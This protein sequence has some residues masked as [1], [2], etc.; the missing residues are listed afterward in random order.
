MKKILVCGANPA[1]QKVLVF[2]ELKNG[3]V[4]RAQ[5]VL[6]FASGKGIN[7][8]RAVKNYKKAGAELVQFTAG[9]NGDRL[10]NGLDTENII[11]HDIQLADGETRICSTCIDCKNKLMTELIE[12]S[13]ELTAADIEKFKNKVFAETGN[14]DAFAIC[15]TMPAN[16]PNDIYLDLTLKALAEN[17]YV[18]A[19]MIFNL[20]PVLEAS[21]GKVLLKINAD[22]LA[23]FT[24]INSVTD[25]LRMIDKKYDTACA[26]ITDGPGKAYLLFKHRIFE[27]ELVELDNVVNAIGCGDTASA[28]LLSEF[29]EK[30]DALEAFRMALGCASANC[31]SLKCAEYDI[32]FA[33]KYAEKITVREL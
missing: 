24:K 32:D 17:K 18:L 22:E 11:H 13:P 3:K 19:D 26:A 27:Y 33:R 1:W 12:P 20:A 23:E 28:V 30:A 7:F 21:D 10:K 31:L 2:P 4:N 16:A 14:F 6:S 8:V 15:G 5:K 25:A 29:M 9:V